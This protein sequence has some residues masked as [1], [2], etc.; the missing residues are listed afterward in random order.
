MIPLNRILEIL[1]RALREESSS[2]SLLVSEA[3]QVVQLD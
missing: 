1:L 3:T 2:D